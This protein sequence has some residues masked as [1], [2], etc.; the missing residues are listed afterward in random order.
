[1]YKNTLVFILIDFNTVAQAIF[2]T[3]LLNVS[4]NKSRNLKMNEL[5]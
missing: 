5:Q 1:M 3:V 4:V 2:F